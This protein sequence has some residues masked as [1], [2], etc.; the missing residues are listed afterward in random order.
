MVNRKHCTEQGGWEALNHWEFFGIQTCHKKLTPLDTN[1]ECIPNSSWVD[2]GLAGITEGP[3]GQIHFTGWITN[4]QGSLHV[5]GTFYISDAREIGLWRHVLTVMWW[6]ATECVGEYSEFL[7]TWCNIVDNVCWQI[8]GVS[9]YWWQHRIKGGTS[10][11]T[12]KMWKCCQQYTSQ[13]AVQFWPLRRQVCLF[14]WWQIKNFADYVDRFHIYGETGDAE[15]TEVLQ[16]FQDSPNPS[17]LVTTPKAVWTGLKL[18]SVNYAVITQ[19]FGV[20]NE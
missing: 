4:M 10:T 11:S 8:G 9:R 20:L 12:S 2:W 17:V 15:Q 6:M 16:K 3:C 7:I 13:K 14:K 5:I 18:T 19:K 1:G